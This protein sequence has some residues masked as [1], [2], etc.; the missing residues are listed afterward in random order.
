MF[1]RKDFKEKTSKMTKREVFSYIV[2][3][4]WPHILGCISIVALI[5]LFGSHYLFGNVKPSFTCV[6]VN[7]KSDIKKDNRIA[8]TYADFAGLEKEKVVIDSEYLFSYGDVKLE[9]VNE[10]SY[11]KFFFQWNNGELDAVIMSEDFYKYCKGMGG[12]FRNIKDTGNFEAYMDDGICTAAVLEEKGSN[13]TES[14]EKNAK[15]L[16]VFPET[17]KHKAEVLPGINHL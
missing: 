8:E 5:F 1:D 10:S 12:T 4:Y 11:E 16:L 14:G 3:Y 13:K 2:S 9:G 17:G 15:L 7:Q 6:M